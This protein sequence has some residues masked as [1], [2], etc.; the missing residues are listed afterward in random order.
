MTRIGPKRKW[1]RD[2]WGYNSRTRARPARR[3]ALGVLG[4]EYKALPGAVGPPL[5]PYLSAASSLP[6]VTSLQ[7]I[8]DPHFA[9]NDFLRAQLG[10]AVDTVQQQADLQG[11]AENNLVANQVVSQPF[12][13]A[14]LGRQDTYTLLGLAVSAT[15]GALSGVYSATG[16]LLAN[17]LLTGS[18]HAGPNAPRQ[19][20]GLR[21]VSAINHNHNFPNAHT[22]SFFYALHIA[23]QRQVYSLSAA[24][25][26]LVSQGL[27]QFLDQVSALDQAGSFNPAVPPPAVP[28]PKGQLNGTLY[29][30]LGAVRELASVNPALSGL[31]LPVVGNFEGRIDVGFVL[32][33]A[34][35]FGIVLTARGPLTGAPPGVTSANEI[36]G[37][38]RLEVSNAQNISDLNGLSTVE[39][40]NQGASLSGGAEASRLHNGVST[41]GASVGYGAGLE[42]GTGIEYTQVIPLGNAYALIPEYPKQS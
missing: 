20:P 21:L 36:A 12:I 1:S 3:L 23:V 39:G 32:D 35:N 31:P 28:L 33:R 4:L 18:A 11:A 19:L 13:H 10:S 8:V 37:D 5:G 16:P 26:N 15:D 34:G 30:S 25:Q 2:M 27:T 7:T 24:Q 41:F 6:Q 9:I 17:A 29:V 40:L 42:Y 38:I 22:S 14:V